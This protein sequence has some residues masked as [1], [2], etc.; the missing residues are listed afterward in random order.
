MAAIHKLNEFEIVSGI[1]VLNAK[2]N[3]CE[4][5]EMKNMEII[6][7]RIFVHLLKQVKFGLNY[8]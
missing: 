3:V 8:E 1:G 6:L 5:D 4:Y 7:K 2:Q